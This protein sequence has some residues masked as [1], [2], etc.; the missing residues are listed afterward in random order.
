MNPKTR[1]PDVVVHSTTPP[2]SRLRLSPCSA[3]GP[4]MPSPGH[5][6]GIA[7]PPCSWHATVPSPPA[8]LVCCW[9]CELASCF[10]PIVVA[11]ET[12][13]LLQKY[14]PNKTPSLGKRRSQCL[15]AV[16]LRGYYR[17]E[18]SSLFPAPSQKEMSRV[19][20]FVVS[21]R[22]KSKRSNAGKMRY[23]RF[24]P[25]DP[26]V[27]AVVVREK[28][29]VQE[30]VLLLWHHHVVVASTLGDL[31]AQVSARDSNKPTE[32]PSQPGI[33]SL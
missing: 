9:S 18:R 30:R 23:T 20:E 22:R 29:L 16:I 21:S 33:S 27:V 4:V 1:G 28:T 26:V 10:H 8:Q 19:I 31:R 2:P 7:F 32:P 24:A 17:R 3:A 6:C 25:L 5:V 15:V 14:F 13:S 11:Q 12:K